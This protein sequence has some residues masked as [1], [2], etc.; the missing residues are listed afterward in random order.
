MYKR[1]GGTSTSSPVVAG[2]A[3][4]LFQ[5]Y[6]NANWQDIKDCILNHALVDSLVTGTLPNNYWGY[7]KVDAFAALTGCTYLSAK[8]P[9][10]PLVETVVFPNPFNDATT[11]HYSF[12]QNNFNSKST[13]Q[14]F[15]VIGEKIKSYSLTKKDGE[16]KINSSLGRGVYFFKFISGNKILKTGKLVK[17]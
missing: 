3:A 9:D 15:N 16:V 1:D 14:I 7:G 2:I 8:N 10:A 13:L 17:V 4:L 6:P 5:R 11:I 12:L